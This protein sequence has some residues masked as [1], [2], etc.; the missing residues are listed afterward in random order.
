MQVAKIF[1][2]ESRDNADVPRP[3]NEADFEGWLSIF[4][5]KVAVTVIFLLASPMLFLLV[6]LNLDNFSSLSSYFL[7]TLF[8]C[9]GYGRQGCY[10]AAEIRLYCGTLSLC[11]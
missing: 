3:W 6:V 7:H 2:G 1:Q 5:R 10:M 9:V 4:T 8:S 11:A